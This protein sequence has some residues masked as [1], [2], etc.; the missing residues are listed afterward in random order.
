MNSR[1]PAPAG[2]RRRFTPLLVAATLLLPAVGCVRTQFYERGKL[3]ESAMQLGQS[4]T[5]THFWHKCFYS[6]EGSAGG[7][8]SS[9]GGGCG[10]F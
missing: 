1:P 4:E 8:G 7:I 5:E 6:R 3:Q 10:C 2:R 9:A